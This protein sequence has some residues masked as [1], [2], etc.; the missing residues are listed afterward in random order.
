MS[1]KGKQKRARAVPFGEAKGR[2]TERQ[3]RGER[4]R[5]ERVVGSRVGE[6]SEAEREERENSGEVEV[7]AMAALGG[8][9]RTSCCSCS[10]RW[11]YLIRDELVPRVGYGG[12]AK[13]FEGGG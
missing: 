6:G 3:A 2:E 11:C 9:P 13:E 4:A 12:Q 7:A 10:C 5:R 8:G 1:R